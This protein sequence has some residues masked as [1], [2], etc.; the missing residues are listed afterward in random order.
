MC[1]TSERNDTGVSNKPTGR[2]IEGE[3]KRKRQQADT[4]PL[5]WRLIENRLP[6]P[7]TKMEHT[8]ISSS[9]GGHSRSFRPSKP[10]LI[11]LCLY[12]RPRFFFLL[13]K[14]WASWKGALNLKAMEES[15][16]HSDAALL[17][18]T[19]ATTRLRF[20]WWCDVP[21]E[22]S[23]RKKSFFPL[24]FLRTG[25]FFMHWREITM[26]IIFHKIISLALWACIF[27]NLRASGVSPLC[28]WNPAKPGTVVAESVHLDQ[29]T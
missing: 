10:P 4:Q 14:Y 7:S 15:S 17:T 19:H 24:L 18:H 13:D 8:V 16:V 22:N 3:K 27:S 9:S 29:Y 2:A 23:L 11:G 5:P 25:P 21:E 20:W 6:F 12:G 28:C 26:E 1:R